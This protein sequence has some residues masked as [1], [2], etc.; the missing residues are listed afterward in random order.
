MLPVL[1][2]RRQWLSVHGCWSIV[3]TIGHIND[4]ETVLTAHCLSIFRNYDNVLLLGKPAVRWDSRSH[5]DIAAHLPFQSQ[6]PCLS[7][8]R[9]SNY[10]NPNGLATLVTLMSN[11]DSCSH[12]SKDTGWTKLE[13]SLTFKW[14]N[15]Y[16]CIEES[17]NNY[18]I[19][20]SFKIYLTE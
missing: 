12:Q 5:L 2:L 11:I 16:N 6:N 17:H 18:L 10:Q 8:A 14:R 15:K 20:V 1:L 3:M 19:I 13:V 9:M 7:F 4:Q